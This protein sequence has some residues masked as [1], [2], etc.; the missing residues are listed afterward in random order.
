VKCIK[1]RDKELGVSATAIAERL[2]MLQPAVSI[3]IKMG[4][5]IAKETSL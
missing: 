4:E 1:I 3:S 2:G 5:K